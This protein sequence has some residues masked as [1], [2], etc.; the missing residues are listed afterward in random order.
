M[1]LSQSTL[2]PFSSFSFSFSFPFAEE[3]NA[4]RR[5]TLQPQWNVHV[6]Y[7]LRSGT[8]KFG[9]LYVNLCLKYSCAA[10]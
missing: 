4:L 3:E 10:S 9:A 7:I 2:N 1:A 6:G 8:V 5:T